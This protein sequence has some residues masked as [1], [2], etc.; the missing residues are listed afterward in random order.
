VFVLDPKAD[1][2]TR[3][4]TETETKQHEEFIAEAANAL[5][6]VPQTMR[7]KAEALPVVPT[8]KKDGS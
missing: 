2:R 7:G 6:N 1:P 5:R 3:E 8:L 4:L